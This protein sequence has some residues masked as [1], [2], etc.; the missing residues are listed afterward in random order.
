MAVA[1][2]AGPRDADFPLAAFAVLGARRAEIVFADLPSFAVR[3]AVTVALDAGSAF[4]DRIS[5]TI[6]VLGTG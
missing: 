4:A 2:L 6:A 1:G 3:V 5:G